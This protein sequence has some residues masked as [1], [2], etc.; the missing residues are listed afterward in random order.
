MTGLI[1]DIR[2]AVRT[3]AKSP[4]FTVV[5]VATLGLGIGANTA[6]FSVVDAA[7]LRP[8]PYADPGRLVYV[9]ETQPELDDAPASAADYLDWARE[10]RSFSA[11]GASRFEWLTLTGRGEPERLQTEAVTANLLPL[12][13]AATVRGGVFSAAEETPG[14]DS[15]VILAEHVWKKLGHPA[16]GETLRLNGRPRGIAGVLPATFDYP[17]G[18]DLWVPLALTPAERANRATHGIQVVGRLAGNATLATAQSE[19]D[20]LE[21]RLAKAHP[22]TNEGHGV[23]LVSLRD[24]LF[25]R[26]RATL[27]VLLGAVAF[28]LLLACANLANLLLARNAT[29][30]REM[31]VRAALGAGRGR[32]VR[33]LLTESCLLAGAGALLALAVA[34]WGIALLEAWKPWQLGAGAVARLDG[35]VLAFTAHAALGTALLF[36]L[37]PAL[38]LSSARLTDALASSGRTTSGPGRGK[39]RAVLAIAQVAIALGLLIGAGL[40]VRSAERLGRVDP[41]FEATDVLTVRVTLP[42]SRYAADA[43]LARFATD[44]VARLAA[45]PGVTAAAAANSPPMYGES[46]S[47]NFE[48][49]GRPDFPAGSAP[50][51]MYRIATP[52]YLRAMGIP[53][54]AGREFTGADRADSVPVAVVSEDMAKKFWPGE[55][56]LGKR[57]KIGWGSDTAFREIVGVAGSVRGER[58]D[59]APMAEIY[60]PFAQHP[61]AGLNL[62]VA[63][64]LPE[65]STLEPVRRAIWSLDPDLPVPKLVSVRELVTR[66]VARRAFSTRLLSAFGCV[67]LLLASLGIY[68]VLSQLVSERRREI[69]IRLTLGAQRRDIFRL[70][71]GRG[72]RLTAV[73]IVLGVAGALVLTKALAALLYDVS[74]TDP[75]TFGVL[76]AVMAAVSFAASALPARRATRVDPMVTLRSE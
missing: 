27:V 13:G 25:G 76:T 70:V 67:A 19:M 23:R 8:L 42:S 31:A 72:A 24:E 39:A 33:Q 47:G 15:S 49:E 28:V 62:L 2:H 71:A 21:A 5:A 63:T 50:L 30:A 41:G 53:L 75:A 74:P 18:T 57:V 16:V 3:L 40:M 12:L 58:L 36:G 56:P 10:V 35:R 22:D 14:A 54:K 65:K 4:G 66:S 43:D 44:V 52:G 68:G 34:A 6:L 38:S 7:L 48:I 32:L 1:S 59:R 46:T 11:L 61:V 73:G 69:G 17:Q 55:S 26:L 20:A 64:A 9:R 37:V 51:A 60:M 29:R 45:L